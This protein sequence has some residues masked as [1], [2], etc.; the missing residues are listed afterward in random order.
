M[1][2]K[3]QPELETFYCK[4]KGSFSNGDRMPSFVMQQFSNWLNGYAKAFNKRY[5]RMG[6]LFMDYIKERL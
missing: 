2:I 4:R 5:R 6:G 1:S 3:T